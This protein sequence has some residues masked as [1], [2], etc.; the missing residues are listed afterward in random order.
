MNCGIVTSGEFLIPTDPV[1]APE[2]ARCKGCGYQL[3]QITT[4][5]CPEC[6]REFD[7]ADP[8]T[9]HFG[10]PAG[11]L[12]RFL[13]QKSSVAPIVLCCLAAIALVCISRWPMGEPK[14]S[15]ADL[16]YFFRHGIRDR[17]VTVTGFLDV[18]AII[19]LVIV[20]L[21]WLL[22]QLGR[23]IAARHYHRS[24]DRPVHLGRR[25]MLL[26]FAV[27][28]SVIVCAIGWP[29]RLAKRWIRVRGEQLKAV[30]AP[31]YSSLS[32]LLSTP[33]ANLGG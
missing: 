11:W 27:I 1:S 16:K 5:R 17:F 20:L 33:P 7:P 4:T 22:R 13:L 15:A 6:G 3:R 2:D 25:A 30:P 9:M 24:R 8:R 26:S 14:A 10:Q 21:Y 12:G 28:T 18:G 32:S 19:L 31:G 29:Y 23:W